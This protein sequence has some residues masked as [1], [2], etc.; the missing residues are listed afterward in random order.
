MSKLMN[1]LV[2][3][4]C[5]DLAIM[6]Q[7]GKIVNLYKNL[8]ELPLD[9]EMLDKLYYYLLELNTTKDLF[10]DDILNFVCENYDENNLIDTTYE[11]YRRRK[12]I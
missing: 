3:K 10:D 4:D 11:F 6:G 12:I 1:D 7:A 2:I 9:Y 5:C 8:F